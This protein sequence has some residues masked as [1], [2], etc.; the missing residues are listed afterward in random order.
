MIKKKKKAKSVDDEKKLNLQQSAAVLFS[1]W[2]YESKW[3][4]LLFESPVF[5]FR[6]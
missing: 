2:V 3:E 5:K 6:V 4:L 1:T